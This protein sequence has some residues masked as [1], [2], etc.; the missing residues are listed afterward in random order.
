MDEKRSSHANAFW[1]ELKEMHKSDDGHLSSKTNS[2]L[3]MEREMKRKAVEEEL[4][5]NHLAAMAKE[6]VH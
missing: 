4:S 3:L 6:G 2:E 1:F 5:K